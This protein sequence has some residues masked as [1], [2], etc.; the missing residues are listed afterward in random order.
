MT[1]GVKKQKNKKLRLL[2]CQVCFKFTRSIAFN[3]FPFL[4]KVSLAVAKTQLCVI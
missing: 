2:Q 1:L 3:G 4:G